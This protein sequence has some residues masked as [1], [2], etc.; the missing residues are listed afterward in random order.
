MLFPHWPPFLIKDS[1]LIPTRKQVIKANE[2]ITR[3]NARKPTKLP[4]GEVTFRIPTG[5]W[6]A[7]LRLYPALNSSDAD[8]RLI[9]WK[10]FRHNPI[11]EQYLVVRSPNRVKRAHK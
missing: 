6:P 11:A 3:G 10:E 7:I 5:D 9:A 4:D 2:A 1:E 8:A